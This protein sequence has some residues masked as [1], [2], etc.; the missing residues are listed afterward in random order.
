MS[1]IVEKLLSQNIHPYA[2]E[3]ALKQEAHIARFLAREY[4]EVLEHSTTLDELGI[5]TSEGPMFQETSNLMETH[6]DEKFEFFDSFLDDQFYAY[7]MA[8][9]GET[10][11]KILNSSISLEEAQK[12]KFQLICER[13]GIRG[14]ERILNLGCG[15]GSFERYLFQ[16]YPDV[17][18]VGVTP[19]KVQVKAIKACASDTACILYNTDFTVI[20]KDFSDL[21][22]KD[23]EPGSFDVVCSIG[24]A[25]QSRNM[26]SFN[27]KVAHYLKPGG[28]AFHHLISSRM[29]IPQFVDPSKTLIGDY[30][31][32]GRIWPM[33]ELAK[34]T[35]ELELEN[36]WF[37]NGMN[38]WTTL[39]DWHRRFWE[40]INTLYE[41]L[42][43]ER[44]RFWND[45]FILCKACFLPLQGEL[46]GNAHYL[47]KKP[48]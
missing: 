36:T 8:Y 46:F 12:N 4:Q 11:E 37:L 1:E 7:T 9:Y 31:P 15:F 23:T 24:L 47:F 29:P 16:Y 5:D 26:Q 18:V 10:P 42:D 2:S 41:H 35:K 48:G 44:I 39:D 22:D 30:F 6:Y 25:E 21:S 40:H 20:L 28:K 45:Y 27:E 33:E 17:Q 34:H 38:Y 14:N 43:I 32:G 19:S 3:Q 13:I